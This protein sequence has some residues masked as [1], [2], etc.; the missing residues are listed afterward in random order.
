MRPH[1][2]YMLYVDFF[3]FDVERREIDLYEY[4]FED[5]GDLDSDGT[6]YNALKHLEGPV[7]RAQL[8]EI[9]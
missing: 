7:L 9:L 3:D 2:N 8:V 6:D 1:E 5:P 4:D